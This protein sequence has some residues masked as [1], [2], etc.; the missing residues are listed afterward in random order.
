MYNHYHLVSRMD[1]IGTI[2]RLHT[3]ILVF[4]KQKVEDRNV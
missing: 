3:V 2:K 4:G 1:S